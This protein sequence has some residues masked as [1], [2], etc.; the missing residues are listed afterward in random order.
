VFGSPDASIVS[1]TPGQP[2]RTAKSHEITATF[3][4]KGQIAAANL[5]GDFHFKEDQRTATADRAHYDPADESFTL[6]G[7][8]RIVD[9]GMAITAN[10]IHLSR[11]TG[12]ALAR[13]DVKTTYND[14]KSQPGGAMLASAE[15]VHVTGT[16]VTASQGGGTAHYTAARLWQGQNIVEAPSLTFDKSRRSLQAQADRTGRVTS[17]FV[18]PQKNGN[19][20]PVNVVSDRLS[21]VDSERKA[22]FS[23]NVR[24][25][26]EEF[27]MTAD[28]VQVLLAA[29]D[30]GGNKNGN[31]LDHIVAQGDIV[32]QQPGRKANG[33]QLV[34][35]AQEQKFVLTGA[36][37][38]KPSIFDAERGQISGDSLT[39][40][41]H[42]GRVLIG[43]GETSPSLSPTRIRDASTK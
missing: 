18:S 28:T 34:Y 11:K 43:S 17:V 24:L 10:S 22:V 36:P 16:S 14:L 9:S 26:G 33:N 15:P 38:K 27:T 42:D 5:V 40:F 6:T 12:N 8:P 37:G 1:V 2:E 30:Q 39:F 32:I 19:S 4:D 25:R 21:Y 7:S 20:T 41:T 23:G 13:G 29:R 3:D 35:T 31:Q